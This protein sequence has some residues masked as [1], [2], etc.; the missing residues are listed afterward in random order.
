M[1][2]STVYPWC[3]VHYTVYIHTLYS[4]SSPAIEN[5]KQ[6][7][8]LNIAGTAPVVSV[9]Y[10]PEWSVPL[11]LIS[12]NDNSRSVR[13]EFLNY[14]NYVWHD[15]IYVLCD[16]NEFINHTS[17]HHSTIQYPL[18]ANRLSWVLGLWTEILN[19]YLPNRIMCF[20]CLIWCSHISYTVPYPADRL[21]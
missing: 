10:Y 17:F 1:Y 19:T 13:W 16:L 5:I 11:I 15:P 20:P 14:F 12:V 21:S 2:Y 4:I 7:Y 3:T 18:R 8:N 6:Q 9:E